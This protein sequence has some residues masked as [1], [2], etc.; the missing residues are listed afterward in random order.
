[1]S[2]CDLYMI[3]FCSMCIL[4]ISNFMIISPRF[5]IFTAIAF[6]YCFPYFCEY[7]TLHNL[8]YVHTQ[9]SSILLSYYKWMKEIYIWEAAFSIIFQ[10]PLVYSYK[11]LPVSLLTLFNYTMITIACSLYNLTT[12]KLMQH[13][14]IC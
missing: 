8:I 10:I 3:S 1:M 14:N 5:H 11:K 7:L 12:E 2:F 13:E 9:Y 6:S 4:H